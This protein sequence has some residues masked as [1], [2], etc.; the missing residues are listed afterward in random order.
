VALLQQLRDERLA[1]EDDKAPAPAPAESAA[2]AGEG[3]ALEA[4]RRA[5]AATAALA[6]T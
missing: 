4:L 3:E 5:L 6:H 2:A 1:D